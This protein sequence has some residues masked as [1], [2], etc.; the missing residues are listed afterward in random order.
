MK[1]NKLILGLA[2][3]AA[4]SLATSAYSAIDNDVYS[5]TRLL[6]IGTPGTLLPTA[7][8]TTNGP[9]DLLGYNGT[10]FILF[11]TGTNAG[12]TLTA[13]IETSPDTNT[14]TQL[15]NF[16]LI[17]TVTTANVTN[18]Y[19]GTNA[20]VVNSYLLPFTATYPTASTAGFATPYPAMN[21]FTNA[22]GAITMTKAGSYVVGI[23]LTD[24][25][26]YLHVV[27]SATGG[28]TN[29]STFVSATLIGNR[30]FAP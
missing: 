19:F 24:A 26:R 2:A 12:G 22:A 16:S 27:F 4:V 5:T 30:I 8:V 11:N 29:G 13:T 23:R 18:L 10:G 20:I 28:A 1:F 17:N 7:L 14:W 15:A 3:V 6:Q 9:V 21:L 25:P